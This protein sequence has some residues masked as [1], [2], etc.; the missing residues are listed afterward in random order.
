VIAGAIFVSTI[1]A[2]DALP[3]GGGDPAFLRAEVV[4]HVSSS[5]RGTG[6]FGVGRDGPGTPAYFAINSRGEGE[7]RHEGF[8]MYI[9]GDGPPAVG[10]YPIVLGTRSASAFTAWY[11][12]GGSV[13][14]WF[15]AEVGEVT[16]E[17]SGNSRIDGNF[18]FSG[19][20]YCVDDGV[21]REGPCTVPHAWIADAPRIEVTG[22]FRVDQRRLVGQPDPLLLDP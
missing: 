9:L 8:H 14:E 11:E 19:F 6:G 18:R 3:F 21:T 4:G 15:V 1:A 2:C 20:R 12:R 17:R 16:I 22:T 10:T 7:F 5:Y 13:D